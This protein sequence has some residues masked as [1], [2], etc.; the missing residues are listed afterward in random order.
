MNTMDFKGL[1]L[2]KEAFSIVQKTSSK[3]SVG[4]YWG[5]FK[6]RW[7]VGRSNYK[8]DPGLYQLGNPSSES[9]VVITAN[10][11]LSFDVLRRSLEKH[12]IWILVIDTKGINVWCAAGKGT[13][14]TEELIH[15]IGITKLEKHVSHRKLI[16]PQ[17]GAPGVAA[18]TIKKATGFKA[19]FGPVR[20]TDLPDYI[21]NGFK[22]TEE[23]RTVRFEVKDRL[24]LAPVEI[25]NSIKYLIFFILIFFLLSGFTSNGFS[26]QSIWREG[27]RSALILCVAYFSG[28]FLSPV[29]LPWIPSRMFAMKGVLIG[30]VGFVVLMCFGVFNY[31]GVQI[32]GWLLLSLSIASFLSMNFTGA[33]TY[34]SL[35]GVKKEMS[36]F[37]PIQLIAAIIGFVIIIISKFIWL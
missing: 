29:L 34:T 8:I 14:G 28:A 32:L 27:V 4:D 1:K 26:M 30:L 20:A 12:D 9:P 2:D 5:A 22:C 15:R 33:S 13:F 31:L 21:R 11:K 35:S 7:S 10:Y 17:L 18:H 23:M 6:V 16:L 24:I 19:E 3:W 36:L 25:S 37:V